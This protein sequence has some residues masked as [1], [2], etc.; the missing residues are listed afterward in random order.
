MKFTVHDYNKESKTCQLCGRVFQAK[1]RADNC[2]GVP[3]RKPEKGEATKEMLTNIN[4]KL[5]VNAIPVA[6]NDSQDNYRS[7]QRD[8]SLYVYRLVDTELIDSTLPPAYYQLSDIPQ[9]L[10]PIS[11]KMM[12]SQGLEA[13]SD[14]K[15]IAV[16]REWAKDYE[17]DEFY[18]YWLYY[19]NEDDTVPGD[20][21]SYITKGRLKSEYHL[22]DGWLKKLGEP[23][24]YMDN[25]HFSRSKMMKLYKKSRVRD[26]LKANV[27]EYA[28]W[29]TRRR[30]YVIN[31]KPLVE[32]S[33]RR[34]ELKKQLSNTPISVVGKSEKQLQ[35]NIMC[36]KCQASTFMSG[37][38]F[39]AINPVGLPDGVPEDHYC[40]DF[41]SDEERP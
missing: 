38:I 32:A 31:S 36:V 39:C 4:R 15:P 16:T 6:Y 8:V 27:E 33:K 35:Q 22:S 40:P 24:L 25:P 23:D 26:F 21:L 14:A 37:G 11:E 30:K 2:P 20:G 34:S 41:Q 5:K 7:K 29:L 13:K 28:Q 9:K 17:T 3:I 1:P 19:Y 10:K 12:R 18:Q